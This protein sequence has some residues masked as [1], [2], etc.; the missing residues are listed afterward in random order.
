ML[1]LESGCQG[2]YDAG[3]VCRRE[4]ETWTGAKGWI[5][6][7]KICGVLIRRG[8]K[9]WGLIIWVIGSPCNVF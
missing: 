6:K 7:E 4:L 1:P 9:S 2:N 5:P 3:A 8:N